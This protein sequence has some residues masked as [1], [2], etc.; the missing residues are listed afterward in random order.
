MMPVRPNEDLKLPEVNAMGHFMFRR[1]ARLA[2]RS[3]TRSLD[4]IAVVAAL[5]PFHTVRLPV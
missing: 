2:R 1:G 5:V 4:A 3:P